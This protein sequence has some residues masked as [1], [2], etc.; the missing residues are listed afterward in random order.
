M[1]ITTTQTTQTTHRATLAGGITVSINHGTFGAMLTLFESGRAMTL[2]LTPEQV[3]EMATWEAHD[4][5]T[6]TGIG[7]V[8]NLPLLPDDDGITPAYCTDDIYD[9]AAHFAAV[10][11]DR[12]WG[13]STRQQERDDI[14][15]L[16]ALA[17]AYQEAQP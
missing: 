6:S 16:R 5:D 10:T 12:A 8:P 17:R 9:D 1:S 13:M 7:I 15:T 3:A 11:R 2:A 4:V 14:A